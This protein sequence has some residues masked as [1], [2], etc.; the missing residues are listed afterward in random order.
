MTSQEAPKD[1]LQFD[2]AEPAS[3]T[4]SGAP[5]CVACHQTLRDTYH[6]VNDKLLC[7]ACRRRIEADWSGGSSSS[8]AG[9]AFLLGLGGA[10]VGAGLYYGVLALTG[11]EVGLIAIVVGFLTGKGVRMGSGN[12][13]GPGYQAMAMV[14][15][16]LAIVAT[17]VPL[18]LKS[19]DS[20]A[21]SLVY[22]AITAI[23]LPFLM[24]A[25][26]LIGIL[27]IGFAVFQAWAMNKR[28]SV[29]FAGPF[30]VKAS[31]T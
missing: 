9:R 10:I 6:T 19:V 20:E 4:A 16:Y 3:A 29:V 25:K 18:I 22:V 15:T 12:R 30:Q 24:G 11:Y 14:L 17:Y 13:G 26:N 2:A 23:A 5:T 8:R 28:A 21:P 7:E 1:S 27:I 31:T